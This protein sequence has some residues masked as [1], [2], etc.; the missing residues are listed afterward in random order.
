MSLTSHPKPGQPVPALQVGMVGGCCWRLSDQKPQHFTLVIAYRGGQCPD[1]ISFLQ[2]V[3]SRLGEFRRR[4]I[5]VVAISADP[6]QC[7]ESTASELGLDRLPIGYGVSPDRAMAWGLEPLGKGHTDKTG[8]AAFNF[9][10]FLVRPDGTLHTSYIQ[11]KPGRLPTVNSV[12]K[13]L[14]RTLERGLDDP[15]AFVLPEADND[16]DAPPSPAP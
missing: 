4:G 7:A 1:S 12:L 10:I 5:A 14:D 2:D 11:S 8:C 15:S 6:R 16:Q 9:G 3:D 13:A